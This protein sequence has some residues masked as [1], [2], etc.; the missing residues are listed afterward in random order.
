MPTASERINALNPFSKKESHSAGSITTYKV[1]TILSWLL[2]LVVT[3]YYVT[4]EP[5]D[6]FTIRRRIWDQN[7]LYRTAFTLNATIVDIYW[8]VL[9][10]LQIGYVAHLFSSNTDY[11]NAAASVGSHFIFHNLLHFA[12]VMLFVRS[13]FVWAE[14]ILIINF[15][16]LSSLYFRHNTY[17]RF[18][19]WPVVSAPLA[20]TFVAIY[21]NGAIMVHDPDNLVAR[22]FGN[23]FIW[24]I[25]VYG[26]FF[27]TIY[28]DYTMGFSLSVLSAAIGVAQFYDKVIAFQW[29]F[30]FTIMAVLF[31][32]TLVIAY[33]A[34]S[35]KE[36]SWPRRS[37]PADQER[38]PLLA[39]D[40]GSETNNT[41]QNPHGSQESST[42]DLK[43]QKHL[44]KK[45]SFVAGRFAAKE[46]TIKAHIQRRLT[47]HDITIL[48]KTLVEGQANAN[49]SGPPM[50]VIK[51]E[52]E[53]ERAREAKITIS[54]DGDYAT[55]VC[56]AYEPPVKKEGCE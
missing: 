49:G 9:F 20:W 34:W 53:G 40:H 44:W 42:E 47:F 36:Y 10:I 33:P 3:L 13:H 56:I 25:L 27:I 5:H 55:A 31:V 51:G 48:R 30:A 1:L 18:I 12:F 19:H 43:A 4:N 22:I 17:P 52:K 24:S 15:A 50:A 14:L 32:S 37:A 38:A 6:G 54:H 2:S 8:V 29:I 35:G 46:A 28:K 16:N 7:Y 39:D 21:W 23:I 41:P 11:V 26:G 45:A